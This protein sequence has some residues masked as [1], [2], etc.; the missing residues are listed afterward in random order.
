MREKLKQKE[1]FANKISESLSVME[2]ENSKL[3]DRYCLLGNVVQYNAIRIDCD[4]MKFEVYMPRELSFRDRLN[5]SCFKS[6]VL[7]LFMQVFLQRWKK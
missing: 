7:L 4:V 6:V 2:Q 1:E 3:Q 5:E